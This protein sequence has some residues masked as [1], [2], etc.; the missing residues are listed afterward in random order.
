MVD[1]RF[2]KSFAVASCERPDLYDITKWSGAQMSTRFCTTA[3]KVNVTKFCIESLS[4]YGMRR[5]SV[6]T[7][8]L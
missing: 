2:L 6:V 1:S 7:N 8:V 4:W 3:L 5:W